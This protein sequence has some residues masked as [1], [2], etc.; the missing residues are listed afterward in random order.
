MPK[1]NLNDIA[2]GFH[3][4][5]LRISRPGPGTPLTKSFQPCNTQWE[6]WS[7]FVIFYPYN[8]LAGKC[9]Y[10]FCCP[11]SHPSPSQSF[12]SIQ[13]I[14]YVKPSNI[15]KRKYIPVIKEQGKETNCE[16]KELIKSSG[17]VL[18]RLLEHSIL[19]CFQKPKVTYEPPSKNP[20]EFW[21][22]F[23]T[24]RL[25]QRNSVS[26]QVLFRPSLPALH[27]LQ[28]LPTLPFTSSSMELAQFGFFVLWESCLVSRA[29][30]SSRVLVWSSWCFKH[31]VNVLHFYGIISFAPKFQKRR[32]KPLCPSSLSLQ[33]SSERTKTTVTLR[34]ISFTIRIVSANIFSHMP[35]PVRRFVSKRCYRFGMFQHPRYDVS[36][37]HFVSGLPGKHLAHCWV[38]WQRYYIHKI[39]CGSVLISLQCAWYRRWGRP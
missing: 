24:S 30:S 39:P 36:H 13:A 1:Y 23:S 6:R 8:I 4:A 16:N 9:I 3:T 29:A 15:S 17:D 33:S 32:F 28:V 37:H 22:L 38:V 20:A 12:F 2:S 25:S 27:P 31:H 19:H 26:Q 18:S 35:L 14:S 5:V 7:P 11:S 21:R 10:R 34:L